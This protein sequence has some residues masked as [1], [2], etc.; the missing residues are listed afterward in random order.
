VAQLEAHGIVCAMALTVERDITARIDAYSTLAFRRPL[1]VLT[2]DRA[3]DVLRHRFSAAHELG[4]LVLHGGSPSGEL[5][6]EREADAFAAEF[7]T[8]RAALVEELPGRLDFAKLFKLSERWGVEVRSLVFRSQELGMIS[9]STARRAYIRLTQA[10]Q[11][12][13]PIQQYDGEVPSMLNAAYELAS[14]RGVTVATLADE[15]RWRPARVRELLG[16]D[17][18]PRPVLR[19]V[20]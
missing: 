6:L 4:H 2:A 14:H 18:D 8:P 20:T 11:E 1:V 17:A 15:L 13:R 3:D 9:E 19:L 10:P 5:W 12:R 16:Q 7:L